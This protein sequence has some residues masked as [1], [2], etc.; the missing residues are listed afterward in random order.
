MLPTEFAQ[1]H[2]ILEVFSKSAR[3]FLAMHAFDKLSGLPNKICLRHRPVSTKNSALSKTV[4]INYFIYLF[5]PDESIDNYLY[6][7]DC[8]RVAMR[9]A[10][11][12]YKANTPQL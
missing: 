3:E 9:I 5:P 6:N 1:H 10:G 11:T 8:I 7:Q 2:A 4:L 12:F